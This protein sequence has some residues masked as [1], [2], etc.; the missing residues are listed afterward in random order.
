MHGWWDETQKRPIHNLKTLS[1]EEGFPTWD[2]A[3]DRY[4]QQRL[5]RAKGGF[6]H[7]F[8]PHYYGER[9]YEYELI[10]P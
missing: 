4:K 5:Y 7:S 10:K 1:P 8:S 6:V 9:K 2:D 3:Y